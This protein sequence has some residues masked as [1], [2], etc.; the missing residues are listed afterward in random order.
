MKLK[1]ICITCKYEKTCIFKQ[2]IKNPIFHCEEYELVPTQTN[3]AQTNRIE[4]KEELSMTEY[5]GI[6]MNC[7]NKMECNIRCKTSVIWRCEEY[8]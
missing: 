4:A 6:C 1:S 8:I 7:D 5:T 3:Q 2:D